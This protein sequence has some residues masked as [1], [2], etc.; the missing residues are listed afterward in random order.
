[1]DCKK[2][3]NLKFIQLAGNINRKRPTQISSFI[4]KQKVKNILILGLS[5]KDNSDDLRDAPSI[6]I[7]KNLLEKEKYIRK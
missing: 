1:M 6:E 2:G 3:I 4:I 5:Y 7:F